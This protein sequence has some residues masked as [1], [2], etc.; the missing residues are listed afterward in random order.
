MSDTNEPDQKRFPWVLR[1][2]FRLA[3]LAGGVAPLAPAMVASSI[4]I[5]NA[6]FY[7]CTAGFLGG[8]VMF[9][10][11]ELARSTGRTFLERVRN[12]F[13][14]KKLITNFASAAAIP[15]LLMVAAHS[16][17]WDKQPEPRASEWSAQP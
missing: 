14:E 13:T 11:M 15:A 9:N 1:Q 10:G 17:G 2:T 12:A 4:D 16:W 7:F 8:S 5:K 3:S 6:G